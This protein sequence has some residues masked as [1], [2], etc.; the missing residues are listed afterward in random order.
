MH[1]DHPGVWYNGYQVVVTRTN[2]GV[3]RMISKDIVRPLNEIEIIENPNIKMSQNEKKQ[4][5]D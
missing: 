5:L 3:F 4:L 1:D 2:E